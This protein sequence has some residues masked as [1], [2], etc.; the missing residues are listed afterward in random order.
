MEHDDVKELARALAG[1]LE[2]LRA[3]G[4]QDIPV[5]AAPAL[6]APPLE[7]GEGGVAKAARVV[8]VDGGVDGAVDGRVVFPGSY[9]ETVRKIIDAMGLGAGDTSLAAAGEAAALAE[10]PGVEFVVA[11]GDGAARALLG[12]EATVAAERGRVAHCGSVP[13]MVTHHPASYG[14]L[15]KKKEAWEDVQQV[16]RILGLS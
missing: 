4:V 6:P 9:G 13:V 12:A 5:A 11:F 7:G 15:K 2:L 8:F 3:Y 1:R 10:A 14:D 16:M